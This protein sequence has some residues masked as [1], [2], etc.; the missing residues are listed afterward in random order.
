MLNADLNFEEFPETD[1][2]MW[3]DQVMRELGTKPFD[4]L[5]D[6]SLGLHIEPYYTQATQQLTDVPGWP[7]NF[8]I[9]QHIGSDQP[10]N[11]AMYALKFGAEALS[12]P[13]PENE[14]D[15]EELMRGIFAEY[16]H[17]FLRKPSYGSISA[18]SRLVEKSGW[19]KLKIRGGYDLDYVEDSS[20]IDL[21]NLD[22]AHFGSWTCLLIDA[23]HCASRG[24]HIFHQL[25]TALSAG[26][27]ALLEFMNK[28]MTVDDASAKIRF[29]FHADGHYFRTIAML[30]AF[31]RLWMEVVSAYQPAFDCS[32]SS[33]IELQSSEWLMTAADLHNNLI[34]NT[35]QSMAG[36]LGGANII[37][38]VPYNHS[39]AGS[40]ESSYRY[41]S[42]TLHL[43]REESYFQSAKD[44]CAGAWYIEEY[45]R[46]VIEK[47]WIN[48]VE[49]ERSGGWKQLST[50]IIQQAKEYGEEMRNKLNSGETIMVGVN[51][52]L[53]SNFNV[54]T[55]DR[56]TS[57]IEK[58][59][60]HV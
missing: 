42:N 19:D 34:R 14:Q 4:N 32:K 2:E 54:G 55:N 57:L 25:T 17:V 22:L 24:G 11:M 30:R 31:R 45:T 36:I 23:G 12:L 51:K 29:R 53:V 27:E 48:F 3:R 40:N 33:F 28:G 35:I 16:I 52:Y 44:P 20:V 13:S 9:G 8:I 1:K 39:V 37:T 60:A 6:E 26:H 38:G 56:L 10:N 18:W 43:L 49:T 41:A 5:I 46:Q 7:E 59:K 15:M 47:A 58:E 21:V 50:S